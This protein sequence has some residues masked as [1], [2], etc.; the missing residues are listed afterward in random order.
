MFLDLKNIRISGIQ[1]EERLDYSCFHIALNMETDVAKLLRTC[2]AW[3]IHDPWLSCYRNSNQ[4]VYF[5]K[6]Y[7]LRNGTIHIFKFYGFLQKK[8]N[9]LLLSLNNPFLLSS[10]F[11]L[12][13]LLTDSSF[14]FSGNDFWIVQEPCFFFFFAEFLE[15]HNYLNNP[16]PLPPLY[17][18][19][20]FAIIFIT[21]PY[22]QFLLL[23]NPG[24]EN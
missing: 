1:K 23:S 10:H 19:A 9:I 17:A 16:S 18:N 4:R 11:L 3:M 14:T 15:R 2:S 21:I 6:C 8:V 13:N 12:L 20:S 5:L 7:L 24:P 22:F